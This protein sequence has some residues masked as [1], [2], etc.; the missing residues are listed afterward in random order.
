MDNAESI[1]QQCI[2]K[3]YVD[4]SLV[5]RED[6]LKRFFDA[7]REQQYAGPIKKSMFVSHGGFINRSKDLGISLGKNRKTGT[8]FIENKEFNKPPPEPILFD[9]ALIDIPS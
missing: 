6:R 9:P 4:S 5:F 2:D 3:K 1:I 8:Y 7:M